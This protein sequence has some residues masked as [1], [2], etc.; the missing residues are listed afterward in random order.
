M[1]SP[2]SCFS[3]PLLS[4]LFFVFYSSTNYM[5]IMKNH[6]D[7]FLAIGL[8]GTVLGRTAHLHNINSSSRSGIGK[9]R[10]VICFF[11]FLIKVLLEHTLIH[12]FTSSL[13]LLLG[14]NGWVE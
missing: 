8:Y 14:Y 2:P 10:S 7:I 12:L 1:A 6:I 5:N 4:I 13:Q 3:S 11:F 9:L